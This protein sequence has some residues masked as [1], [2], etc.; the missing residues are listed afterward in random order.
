MD[1]R[2]ARVRPGKAVTC[3][4][5]ICCLEPLTVYGEVPNRIK[6]RVRTL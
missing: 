3:L 2:H 6:D 1:K 4:L 5:G